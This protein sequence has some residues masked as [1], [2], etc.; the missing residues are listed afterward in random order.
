V[1]TYKDDAAPQPQ[2]TNYATAV[3]WAAQHSTMTVPRITSSPPPKEPIR[4]KGDK[5]GADEVQ[6]VQNH[7]EKCLQLYMNQNEVIAALHLQAN[8]EPGF[9]SLVWQRL[10]EQNPE[11]FRAYHIRLR[12]KEQ[13]T[14]FNFLASQQFQA[15]QKANPSYFQLPQHTTVPGNF[16]KHET[17]FNMPM[18]HFDN[19]N[20]Q[21]TNKDDNIL[22]TSVFFDQ[23][24]QTA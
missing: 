15:L 22:D 24:G 7:I 14:A 6:C 8:I 5:I 18:E 10:E 23:S 9:T 4:P 3:N 11:F 16:F 19:E 13:I 2:N 17:A 1:K 20:M 21:D 12:I